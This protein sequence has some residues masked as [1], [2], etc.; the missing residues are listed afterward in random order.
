MFK[1][2]TQHTLDDEHSVYSAQIPDHLIAHQERFEILWNLHP[3]EHHEIQIHGK[4]VKTPR[5]QQA[6]GADYH[7]TG[8]T[9]DATKTPDIIQP[10]LDWARETIFPELNGILVNWYDGQFDHYIGKHRDSVSN[11]I[12]G[13]PIAT[14]SL[15]EERKF[16]M[17]PWK[18]SGFLDFPATAGSVF[19][20]PYE[21]NLAWTHEVP[22]SKKLNGRRI[23]VTMRAFKS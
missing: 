23:S 19:V 13:A 3:E 5:W 22:P 10:Y 20:I 1:S 8:Q 12:E 15:G 4:L 11:M 21:T 18:Q 7:F 16:R 2:F 14:V 6:Y 17:R 9:F